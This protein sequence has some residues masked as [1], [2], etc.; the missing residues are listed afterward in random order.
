MSSDPLVIRTSFEGIVQLQLNRPE[1]RNALSA[2]LRVELIAAIQEAEVDPEIRVIIIAGSAEVFAAGADIK[3]MSEIDLPGALD[4]A[5][6]RSVYQVVADCTKPVIAAVSGFALG[7]GFELALACDMIVASD[8]A[9]FGLPEVTLG[10]IP[11][12][13]GTQRLTQITGKQ[14]AMEIILT[15]RR[16]D[17]WEAKSLGIVNQVTAKEAWLEKAQDLAV[18]IAKRPPI[19]VRLA[20]QAIKAADEEGLTAGL[21]HERRLF[22]LAMA[23]EDR[24]EGMTAFIEKRKPEYK[25]R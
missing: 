12:G 13:G 7:A 2:E 1:A 25:G 3:M 9:E 11:G 24:V 4:L 23:T 14:A 5:R 6:N 10:I 18:V 15:G 16:I 19:A 17:A 21:A 22:E 20:K 8:K